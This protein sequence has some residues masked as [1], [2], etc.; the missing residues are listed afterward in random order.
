MEN[1]DQFILQIRIDLEF[2]DLETHLAQ[3]VEK[4][5]PSEQNGIHKIE[6]D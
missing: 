6:Q 3:S 4:W 5:N 1:K 2:V